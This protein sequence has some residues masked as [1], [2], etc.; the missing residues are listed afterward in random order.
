MI[1]V[2]HFCISLYALIRSRIYGN[3]YGG[4]YANEELRTLETKNF[5]TV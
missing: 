1:L 3:G 4:G 2:S 5:C